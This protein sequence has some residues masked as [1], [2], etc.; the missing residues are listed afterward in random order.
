MLNLLSRINPLLKIVFIFCQLI[1]IYLFK[2]P[3]LI[4]SV[5]FFFLIVNFSTSNTLTSS[6]HNL[7]KISPLLLSLFLLG[8]LFG[9]SVSKDLRL[10]FH[11]A[12]LA[13]YTFTFIY[14]TNS[15]QF[16]SAINDIF[17]EKVKSPVT[18][19][20][21]GL[22][23]FFP[24]LKSTI[25]TTVATYKLNYGSVNNLKN[26]SLIFS[27]ILEKTI[28]KIQHNSLSVN[29]LRQKLSSKK[30]SKFDSLPVIIILLQISIIFL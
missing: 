29:I 15:Y 26:I 13:I 24:L 17:P 25:R 12:I 19:F 4:Y 20:C 18:T 23:Y 3:Y 1:F 11:I 9:N 16:V 14:S 22:V 6:F 30:F 2:N 21:Y 8:Y 7:L 28:L 27:T 5:L 10:I